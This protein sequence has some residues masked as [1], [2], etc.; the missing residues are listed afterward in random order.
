MVGND[1]HIILCNL[2]DSRIMSGLKVIDGVLQRLPL[3]SQVAKKKKAGSE[4]G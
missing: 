4:Y 3:W 1:E 2:V